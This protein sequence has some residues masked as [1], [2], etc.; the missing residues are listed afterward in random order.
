MKRMIF[1][2]YVFVALAACMLFSCNTNG[3]APDEDK[4]TSE[5]MDTNGDGVIDD[6][7]KTE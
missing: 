3:P 2:K 4:K 1:L 5:Q 7:D 6:A